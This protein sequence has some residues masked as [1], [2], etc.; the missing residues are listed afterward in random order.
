MLDETA[1]RELLKQSQDVRP[2]TY[3]AVQAGLFEEIVDQRLPP[4]EGPPAAR[5]AVP[6]STVLAQR[7]D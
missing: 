6:G 3:R 2:Y 5:N 1:Y 4:G 7:L